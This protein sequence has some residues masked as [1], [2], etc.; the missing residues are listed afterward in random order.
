MTSSFGATVNHNQ[1]N[2]Y[3]LGETNG[4]LRLHV[5]GFVAALNDQASLE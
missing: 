3:H 4:E 1:K 5:V 2:S